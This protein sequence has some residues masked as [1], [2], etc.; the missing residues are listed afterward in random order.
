MSRYSQ[1]RPVAVKPI[2][3]LDFSYGFL[4]NVEAADGTVLGHV[5]KD[6]IQ[7]AVVWGANAPKPARASKQKASGVSSSFISFDAIDAARK[8][9]WRVG[10]ARTRGA[11]NS[12]A[13]R[14]VYVT[15]EGIKYAWRIPNVTATNLGD[16]AQLGIKVA[17]PKDRDLVF[18]ASSPKPPRAKKKKDNST[19]S[20]FYDP[21]VTLPTGFTVVG[22][23]VDPEATVASQ[24]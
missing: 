3:G 12:T 2:R 21:S 13:T 18:G 11:S 16:L 23:A 17:D 10:K 1:R 22:N 24:T 9:G 5:A 15:I 7:G 20:T 14:T 4:T 6:Q 19:I 8:A